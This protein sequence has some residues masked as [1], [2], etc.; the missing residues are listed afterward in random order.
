MEGW[1]V[2]QQ[3]E[4]VM[5]IGFYFLSSERGDTTTYPLP[6]EKRSHGWWQAA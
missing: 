4:K 6:G 2:E 5:S 1:W 3:G